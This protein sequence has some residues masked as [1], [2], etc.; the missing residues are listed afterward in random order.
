MSIF[1]GDKT[2]ELEMAKK[3]GRGVGVLENV[4][5]LAIDV[6]GDKLSQSEAAQQLVGT[7]PHN[8]HV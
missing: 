3:L 2:K 1:S 8:S 4:L 7:A 6:A 5:H